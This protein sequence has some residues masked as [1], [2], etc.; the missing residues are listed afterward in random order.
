MAYKKEYI[1]PE[2]SIYQIS[3]RY[4]LISA[5][6]GNGAVDLTDGGSD[7]AGS[8]MARGGDFWDDTDE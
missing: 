2:I 1:Q 7:N 3:G 4:L 6:G 8:G 5:S